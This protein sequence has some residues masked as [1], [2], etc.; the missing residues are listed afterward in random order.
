M[1]APLTAILLVAVVGTTDT[2]MLLLL[3]ISSVTAMVLADVLR[4][5]RGRAG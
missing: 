2:I 5:R 4:R 1:G 3:T